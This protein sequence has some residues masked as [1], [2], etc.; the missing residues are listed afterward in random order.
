MPRLAAGLGVITACALAGCGGDA[1]SAG[2]IAECLREAEASVELDPPRE[3]D[4]ASEDFSPVLTPET[5][6][7][8]AGRLDGGSEFELFI[9]SP[10]AADRAEDRAQEF[11]RLFGVPEEHVVRN[12]TALLMVSTADFGK[13]DRQ[14]AQRCVR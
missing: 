11:L 7:A 9:S 12:G 1:P 4:P 14:T 8:A 6:L 3:S 13:A 5:E 2:V 10:G